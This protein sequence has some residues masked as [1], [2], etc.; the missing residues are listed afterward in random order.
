MS[1]AIIFHLEWLRGDGL[2]IRQSESVAEHIVIL[3]TRLS[4]TASGERESFGYMREAD[5]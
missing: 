4:A 1:E 2:P 5:S 3:E